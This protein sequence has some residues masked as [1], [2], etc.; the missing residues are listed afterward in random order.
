MIGDAVSDGDYSKALGD[1]ILR[2]TREKYDARMVGPLD[3]KKVEAAAEE[4]LTELR[5]EGL[6]VDDVDGLVDEAVRP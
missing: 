4:L 1:A 6:P 5:K 3:V 2:L